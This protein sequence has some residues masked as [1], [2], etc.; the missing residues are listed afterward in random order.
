ME[1]ELRDYCPVNGGVVGVTAGQIDLPS[2]APLSI[3]S[4]G[5]LQLRVAHCIT[6]VALLLVVNDR[7]HK[8]Y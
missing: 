7:P 1:V 8:Q 2:M 5:R 4:C 3:A 6:K